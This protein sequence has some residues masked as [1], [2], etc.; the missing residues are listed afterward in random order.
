MS[1]Q[2]QYSNSL[3]IYQEKLEEYKKLTE[4]SKYS[5]IVDSMPFDFLEA[6]QFCDKLSLFAEMGKGSAKARMSF[7]S[8]EDAIIFYKKLISFKNK[9]GELLENASCIVDVGQKAADLNFYV[10]NNPYLGADYKI[11]INETITDIAGR[12]LRKI[13]DYPKNMTKEFRW[14]FIE[15]AIYSLP[16]P[17]IDKLVQ[18]KVIKGTDIDHI[19]L[20]EEKNDYQAKITH[21]CAITGHTQ[22]IIAS[23]PLKLKGVTFPNADGSSRQEHLKALKEYVDAHPGEVIPLST[24][25]YTYQPEIGDAEPAVRIFWG[26]REI[27]NIP[28]VA[29]EELQEKYNHPQCTAVLK[30]VTAPDNLNAGCT[31]ILNVIAPQLLHPEQEVPK[32]VSDTA[33]EQ[34]ENEIS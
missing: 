26:T 21:L 5:E 2:T 8:A 33:P 4:N 29:A 23:Y 10:E 17:E 20:T 18:A 6:E 12:C 14:H 30:S 22:P 25:S 27:G 9:T 3:T 7:T 16:I 31:I 24:E 19:S 34:S 28:R 32:Q 15:S 13:P 1:Y 11:A